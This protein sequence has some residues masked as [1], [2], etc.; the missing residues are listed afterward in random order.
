MFACFQPAL[1]GLVIRPQA[2]FRI[3]SKS[4]NFTETAANVFTGPGI[5]AIT[6]IVPP[7]AA[8]AA[9]LAPFVANGDFIRWPVEQIRAWRAEHPEGPVVIGTVNGNVFKA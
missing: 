1:R 3:V 5:D 6:F 7:S 9:Y 4:P 2:T 8:W